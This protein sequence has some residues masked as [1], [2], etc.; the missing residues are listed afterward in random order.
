MQGEHT[1]LRN[2]V[3]NAMAWSGN[4][5]V[6]YTAVVDMSGGEFTDMIEITYSKEELAKAD[7]RWVDAFYHLVDRRSEDLVDG[8]VLR[9]VLCH[10]LRPVKLTT[11][12]HDNRYVVDPMYVMEMESLPET[13]VFCCYE[14]RLQQFGD[15]TLP[16]LVAP[17]IFE[18]SLATMEVVFPGFSKRLQVAEVTELDLNS[19]EGARFV[20]GLPSHL[21]GVKMEL[22]ADMLFDEVSYT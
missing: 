14:Y 17:D 13:Y 12:V 6:G 1:N 16:V 2:V 4:A 21:D 19:Q 20:L 18:Y 8:P 11:N 15:L 3:A 10:W 22:P 9:T 7:S 5:E